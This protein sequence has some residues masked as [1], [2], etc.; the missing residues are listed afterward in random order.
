MLKNTVPIN[1][2]KITEKAASKVK[3][4]A[5][6]KSMSNFGL[7]VSVKGGGCSGLT[8]VL[9]IVDNHEKEDKVIKSSGIEVY[10]PKKAFVFLAGTVLD[11]SDGLNGKGFEFYNP[12]AKKSCGCGDSFSV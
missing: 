6:Q 2:I 10:I 3:Q 7:K 11:F 4:F 5:N 8:Y 12:N 9:D 1:T